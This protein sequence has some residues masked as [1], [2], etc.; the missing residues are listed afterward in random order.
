[1]SKILRKRIFVLVIVLLICIYIFVPYLINYLVTKSCLPFSIS[2]S[3]KNELE[4]TWLVFWASYI[5]CVL[6]SIV[7]FT[8]LFLTLRQNDK[9]NKKNRDEAHCENLLIRE[10]QERSNKYER[11]MHYVSEIRASAVS[12][13]HAVNNSK[14]EDIYT[15]ISLEGLNVIDFKAIRSLL[16]EIEDDST[17]ACV[18]ME[19]IFSYGALKDEEA[20]KYMKMIKRLSDESYDCIRDLIWF[21]IECKHSL[22]VNQDVIRSEVYK[23]ASEHT[24]RMV[25]PDYKYIWNIIIEKELMDIEKNRFEIV[26]KWHDEWHKINQLLLF[27]LRDLVKHYYDKAQEIN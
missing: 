7:T 14:A 2:L 16:L 15:R 6:S 11:A 9:E 20:E 25:I 19:M 13:Y 27:S 17:R 8:V 23:Y 4:R 26:L 12:V 3:G 21:Y 18:E 10:S 24:N 1:M 5:G 22:S